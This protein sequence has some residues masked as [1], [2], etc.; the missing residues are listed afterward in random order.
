[1]KVF[2][3]RLISAVLALSALPALA[4]IPPSQFIIRN[5]ASKRTGLKSVRIVSEVLG[6][7]S[8]GHPTGQKFRSVTTFNPGAR[9]M[10][11][12]ALDDA[13][14]EL[15]GVEKRAA[16]LPLDL[17]VLFDPSARDLIAALKRAE[18]RL[19]ED[20]E[21][22]TVTLRRWDGSVAWVLGS[23]EQKG[24]QLWIEKD[25]FLPVRVIAGDQDVQFTKYR[26]AQD[27][28]YPRATTWSTHGGVRVLEEDVQEVQVNASAKAEQAPIASGYTDLGNSSPLKELI[29]K[30]Y[31]GLR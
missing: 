3:K 24:P 17:L 1:M 7:D 6:F 2:L 9:L 14:K 20:G 22:D 23:P 28:P 16:S 15:F 27:L 12:Q 19:P 21:P 5:V 11:S 13:G 29:R 4:Y 26:Y 8:S 18:L 25:T 30:Y 10:K 31:A